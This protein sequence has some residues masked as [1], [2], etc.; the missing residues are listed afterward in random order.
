[1]PFMSPRKGLASISASSSSRRRQRVTIF[2][3]S[4]M[5][6]WQRHGHIRDKVPT[7]RI[8]ALASHVL[9]LVSDTTVSRSSFGPYPL[10]C[11]QEAVYAHQ[12]FH[13]TC[14][15]PLELRPKH[16]DRRLPQAILIRV[17]ISYNLSRLKVTKGTKRRLIVL[18]PAMTLP[19]L[20]QA[21]CAAVWIFQ[22]QF[23]NRCGIFPK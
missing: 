6:A 16:V 5:V 14:A 17:I 4:D 23:K 18:T 22:A 1:M 19:S 20:Q 8:A 15:T 3:Y 9:C 13:A 7:S 10:N 21:L 11:L 12:R 2:R